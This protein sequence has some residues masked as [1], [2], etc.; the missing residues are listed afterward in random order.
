MRIREFGSDIRLPCAP[1]ASSRDPDAHRRHVGLDEL[2]RVVDRQP[3]VD[4]AARRVDV[5]RD[6]LVRVLRLEVQQLRDDEVGDL[7]VDR[8]AEEDDAL[9]EQARVDVE[10]ALTACGA[11]DDHR[12]K[13][14][15][16]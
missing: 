12:D 9:V 1:P 16:G 7:V 13:R 5:D 10:L 8:A 15:G 3:G 2:H 4:R 14:H 6:V 11:L